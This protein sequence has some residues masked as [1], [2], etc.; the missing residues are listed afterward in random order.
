MTLMTSSRRAFARPVELALY[1]AGPFATLITAPILARAL[2]P[3]AR[4]Q[5]GVA[6]A[7]ATFALTLGA[8]GQ[9]ETYMAEARAGR[10]GYAQQTRIALI[11]GV[12][13]A[14]LT[15]IGLVLLGLPPLTAV[16][17]A[18]W[19]PLLNQTNL[20][21]S[22]SVASGYLRPPAVSGALGPALRVAALVVLLL[23]ATLTVNTAIIV[24]QAALLVA[25]MATVA[26]VARRVH[27][28]RSG[29]TVPIARLVRSGGA[30]ITFDVFN[31]LALRSDLIVLQLFVSP[32]VV[33]LYAAPASLT[34]AALALSIAFKNRIQAAVVAEAPPGTIAREVLPVLVLGAVGAAILWIIAPWLVAV[35]F[36][37]EYSGSVVL[38]R[39]LG[40]ATVPLLL[41]D[42]VQGVLV[43]LARRRALIAVGAVS[44]AAVVGSLLVLCPPFGAVGAA[45][46]CLIGYTVAASVGWLIVARD[47]RLHA[48]RSTVMT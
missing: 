17:T 4:G 46:A 21:R 8:W 40:L 42:L 12:L 13:T 37:P 45:I 19:V 24:T 32:H 2:G 44:A 28:E 23:T 11:G 18:V 5:Y 30:V 27:A 29:P 26:I 34:T 16:V 35:F 9:A 1:A 25:A 41:F 39:L 48:G 3:A 14:V 7:V 38:L 31:A 10:F 47:L 33:G 15:G 20:W 6:M 43:V 22:V 36:G